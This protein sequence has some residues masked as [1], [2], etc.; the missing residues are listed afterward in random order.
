VTDKQKSERKVLVYT[1]ESESEALVI[2]GLLESSGIQLSG[3]ASPD[4][5]PLVD[6][7]MSRGT[8]H[9]VDVYVY[10]PDANEARRLINA[11]R[12]RHANRKNSDNES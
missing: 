12:L 4:P 5:F 8:N 3:T 1:A 6:S 9:G 10:E 2:R 7:N 11:H